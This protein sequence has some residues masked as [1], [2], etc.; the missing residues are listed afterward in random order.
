MKKIVLIWIIVSVLVSISTTILEAQPALTFIRIF[1]DSVGR[2]HLIGVVGLT[3]VALLLPLLLVMGISNFIQNKKNKMPTDFTGKTGI[4]VE[5]EK[6]LSNAALMYDI[7]I[8]TEQKAKL[9]MGK[10][11]FIELQPGTH[12]LQIKLG[13]NIYSPEIS[14][15]L[16]QEKILTY[17][18]KTDFRKSLTTLIPKGQMLFLN[19]VPFSKN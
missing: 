2:Y 1:T 18:T 13:K 5:R 19:R 7:F 17:Q 8:N 4:V 15:Q 3:F 16:E 11:T 12:T 9:G 14:V 10:S 6:E